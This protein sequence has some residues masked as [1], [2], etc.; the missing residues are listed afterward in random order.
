MDDFRTP[1]IL[2]LQFLNQT[3]NLLS[4][5][6]QA[7]SFFYQW[8]DTLDEMFNFGPI[9]LYLPVIAPRKIYSQDGSLGEAIHS[10]LD[11]K[12]QANEFINGLYLFP[13]IE[14][15]PYN[16]LAVPSEIKNHDL[17][18]AFL[19]S[20]PLIV[21]QVHQL[22]QLSRKLTVARLNLSLKTICSMHQPFKID[23]GLEELRGYFN[24]EWLFVYSISSD[25]LIFASDAQEDD[26]VIRRALIDAC[27]K[28]NYDRN[29]VTDDDYGEKIRSLILYPI[30]SDEDQDAFLGSYSHRNTSLSTS[31][32]NLICELGSNIDS[33]RWL[34]NGLNQISENS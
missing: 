32:L 11:T 7:D 6:S 17:F 25:K 2:N 9:L 26:P 14:N 4:S 27:R 24:N 20:L 21:R 29:M 13:F 18:D 28:A 30:Y 23:E 15:E 8:L 22:D 5:C 33:V 16:L 12:V 19:K 10:H 1:E 31:D 34:L 3:M